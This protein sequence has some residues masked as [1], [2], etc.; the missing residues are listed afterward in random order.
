M[1]GGS[2][3][4]TSQPAA[5]ATS[6]GLDGIRDSREDVRVDQNLAPVGPISSVGHERIGG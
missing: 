3:P 4:A 2:R 6:G 1:A 5:A